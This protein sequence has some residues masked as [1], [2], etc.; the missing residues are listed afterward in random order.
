MENVFGD[1]IKSIEES[2][3]KQRI[4]YESLLSKAETEEQKESLNRLMTISTSINE[5]IRKKDIVA[6][7]KFLTELTDANNTNR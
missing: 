2:I 6:L 1:T 3:E 4:I 7:N 5:A